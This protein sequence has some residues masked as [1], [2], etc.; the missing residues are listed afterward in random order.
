M[1][2]SIDAGG[3]LYINVGDNPDSA[4][5][6]DTLLARASA[7]LRRNPEIDVMVKG[8]ANVAYGRVI[9]AMVLLQQAGAAKVG[10]ITDPLPAPRTRRPGA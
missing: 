9:A 2:I 5:D 1:V 3:R 6:E 4:I 7:M 8:D 10:F